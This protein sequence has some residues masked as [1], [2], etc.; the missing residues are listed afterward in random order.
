[1]DAYRA[2]SGR[3]LLARIA[4][5]AML[6]SSYTRSCFRESPFVRP[7]VR[8]PNLTLPPNFIADPTCSQCVLNEK[9][10]FSF[11]TTKPR[12][13]AIVRPPNGHYARFKSRLTAD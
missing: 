7:Q 13:S 6:Y 3:F 11:K 9:T 8:A 2:V 5:F 10:R 4:L 12:L 1:M